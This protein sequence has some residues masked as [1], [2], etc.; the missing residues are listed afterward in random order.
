MDGSSKGTTYRIFKHDIAF[1]TYLKLLSESLYFPILKFRTSN[2]KLPIE[3]GR[4]ENVDH[5]E[6]KC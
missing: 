5:A 1:E 4:W 2:H 3:T 6:L